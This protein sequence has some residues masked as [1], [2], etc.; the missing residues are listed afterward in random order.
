MG[1]EASLFSH[2]CQLRRER[3]GTGGADDEDVRHVVVLRLIYWKF[4][5]WEM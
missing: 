1:W 5:V 4:R 3:R 2:G